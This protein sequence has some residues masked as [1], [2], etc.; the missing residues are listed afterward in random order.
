MAKVPESIPRRVTGKFDSPYCPVTG[1]E[2]N[3]IEISH[4]MHYS[5]EFRFSLLRQAGINPSVEKGWLRWC[6]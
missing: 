5:E 6:V 1:H 2:V 3:V 4:L